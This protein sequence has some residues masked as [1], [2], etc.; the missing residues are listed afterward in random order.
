M[1]RIL[2]IVCFTTLAWPWLY[3]QTKRATASSAKPNIIFILTDDLG[4]GDIGV[5]FQNRR[6]EQNNRSAPWQYTPNI[7]LIAKRGAILTNN[8]C[9]A[10]VCAPSRASLLLGVHQGH[11]NIRNNQFDK[12]LEDNYNI[13]NLLKSVG[14]TTAAIGKWG[15]QGTKGAGPDWPAHPLRRGFDYFFGYMRHADGH[16]HYPKEGLYRGSKQVWENRTNITESLD[17]CFTADLWTANAKQWLINFQQSP[18]KNSP[19]FM[20]LAYDLPHAVLEVPTQSYPA[21]NGLKGGLQWLGTPGNMINTASGTPDSWIHPDYRDATYDH[22]SSTATAEVPWPDTYKRYATINRRLDDAVGDLLQLLKDLKIDDNTIIVFTSDNGPSIESY[23]PKPF[24]PVVPTFFQSYG[25]FD[26]IKRDCWEGGIRMPT[27]VQ[28]PARIKGGTVVS[29]PGIFSDWLATFLDAAGVQAPVRSD[30]VSLLPALT[31]KGKQAASK[32]YIEYVNNEATPGFTAF[33]AS[34]RRRLRGQM[35]MI[36]VDDYVGVRYDIKTAADDFE[37]YDIEKDPKETTNLAGNAAFDVLQQQMKDRVLQLRRPDTNAVRPYDEVAVP[38]VKTAGVVPG[39]NWKLYVDKH[40][41]IAAPGRQQLL[42]SG[43]EKAITL[44]SK[45]FVAGSVVCFEG[46]LQVPVTGE[47]HFSLL[48]DQSFF[49]KIHEAS[50]LDGDYGYDGK[51]IRSGSVK[52]AA[53][54][55][56]FRLYAKVGANTGKAFRFNWEGP[57]M[58]LRPVSDGDFLFR[59]NVVPAK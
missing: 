3:G 42:S 1:K 59:D 14:Y 36:R 24:V 35:Q 33:E 58:P 47:Y 21:G 43:T 54:R 2:A 11:A 56:P 10:P 22:D 29:T 15:L 30:G 55:H 26:G 50:V 5:F 39:V 20:Y 25:P 44:S 45:R 17:K 13:A 41:W 57:G 16:E 32:V 34:R 27:L 37:I 6:K 4:V 19:F 18:L 52:L 46:Y 53:G 8:Y 31:G 49:L 28:W 51:T 40:A 12:A 23:L 7:D 38:A 48:S 9:N